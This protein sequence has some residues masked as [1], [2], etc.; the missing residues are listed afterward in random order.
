MGKF[1]IRKR[2]QSFRYAFNGIGLLIK[3]EHNAW[4]HL[5]ATVVV[6]GCGW[7]V[8]LTRPEWILII[9]AIGLVIIAEAFNT[10]IEH[11]ANAITR[12]Q[13][14]YI[15]N[16]KDIAAGAVFIAA[17]VAAIIGLCIFI[18]HLI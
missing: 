7:L 13:N 18:P 15:K 6:I 3:L 5:F 14:N 10:A 8:K 17:L 16:A 12:D 2:I 1:S 11:L 4:I 9:L